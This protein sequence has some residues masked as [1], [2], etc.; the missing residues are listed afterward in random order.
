MVIYKN[1]AFINLILILVI[2]KIML[3]TLLYNLE[4]IYIYNKIIYNTKD[5][6]NNKN[7]NKILEQFINKSNQEL[8]AQLN[9]RFIPDELSIDCHNGI[10]IYHLYLTN[11]LHAYFAKRINVTVEQQLLIKKYNLINIILKTYPKATNITITNDNIFFIEHNLLYKYIINQNKTFSY[12]LSDQII[13]YIIGPYYIYLRT[14][15]NNNLYDIINIIYIND[16]NILTKTQL[17][18][19]PKANSFFL[20]ANYL[21][22]LYYNTEP[23]IYK[24][25]HDYTL[26]IKKLH[27]SFDQTVNTLEPP[28]NTIYYNIY[29][30]PNKQTHIAITPQITYKFKL[31]IDNGILSITNNNIN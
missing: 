2:N 13:D 10:N 30:D 4:K 19:I 7:I 14:K 12:N 11:T 21:I 18:I 20:K 6:Y 23:Q 17:A 24:L 9:Y 8:I 1:C 15:A 5:Y 31:P 22:F 27:I 29:W 25:I 16:Q 26:T 28:T 3:L